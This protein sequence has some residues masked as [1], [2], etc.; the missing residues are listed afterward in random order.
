MPELLD[1]DPDPAAANDLMEHAGV[2]QKCAAELAAA[3]SALSAVSPSIILKASPGMKERT[4][5]QILSLDS[6]S[7]TVKPAS[8][9]R[10]F[11]IVHPWRYAAAAAVALAIILV[12]TFKG[13]S[14]NAFA[15]VMEQIRKVSACTYTMT[16]LTE[17]EPKTQKKTFYKDP[18]RMRME[19][20]APGT[21]EDAVISIGDVGRKKL[22][23]LK[24][25]TKQYISYDL[26]GDL[27]SSKQNADVSLFEELRRIP[28]SGAQSIGTKEIG[29]I[30][31]EGF[32]ASQ[33]GMSYVIWAD[34][35]T[36]RIM[37][38]EFESENVK[39]MKGELSDFD[40]DAQLDDSLFSVDPPPG[41]TVTD[42]QTIKVEKPSEE[43]FIRFL[44]KGA[45][46]TEG[47]LFLPSL[48]AVGLKKSG[49]SRKKTAP[50]L[51]LPGSQEFTQ[52]VH[53]NTMALMFA[54][55]MTGENDF[56]YAGEGVSLGDAQKPICWYKP[57]GAQ[58]YRVIYGDLSVRDTA[59]GDLPST[60]K[61]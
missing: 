44:R 10:R 39:G 5:K 37:L 57:T 24:P 35:D 3:M 43:I 27:S 60:D 55:M 31:A 29:G 47:D 20:V 41:Y 19:T 28:D 32:R 56:H 59:P 46:D 40:F 49:M 50:P 34:P 12:S 13:G 4:M 21:P 45:Q 36:Q 58:N 9:G 30:V 23:I 25:V 22:I 53:E 48:D 7:M 8:T 38:V 6:Q 42:S 1:R 14:S 26:T 2:C 54:M 33:S 17:N 18:G 11:M 16:H 51:P 61:K 52:L 15:Q